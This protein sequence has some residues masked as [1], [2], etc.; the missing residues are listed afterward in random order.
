MPASLP[1]WVPILF[2]GL[3]FLGYRQSLP[4]TVR[5]A[6]LVAVALAM[7]GVSLYG[8]VGVF[9][10]EPLALLLWAAGYAA[11]VGFGARHVA[12]RGMAVVGTAVRIPGSWAP[13]ALLLAIFAARFGLG[14]ATALRLPLLHHLGFVA[15]MS[16]VLGALS[17]GFGARALAVQRCAAAGSPAR[18]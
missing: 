16:G 18:A 3:L 1:T 4:R 11:A 13:L 5:P 14:F 2:L 12:A 7:L 15:A 17:G 10:P 6:T 9:G 8:V